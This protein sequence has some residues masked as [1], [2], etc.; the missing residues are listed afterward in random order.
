MRFYVDTDERVSMRIEVQERG[1]TVNIVGQ[2][3]NGQFWTIITLLADG[4][5]KR[6]SGI[7]NTLGLRVNEEGRIIEAL[8]GDM[9][10]FE[11]YKE[12]IEKMGFVVDLSE[13]QEP[14]ASV[15]AF[16]MMKKQIIEIQEGGRNGDGNG[17]HVAVSK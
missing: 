13:K 11:K 1:K 7:P 9:K 12:G 10:R 6:G 3:H 2:D 5:F 4:T 16:D 17:R 15:P 8:N 14:D